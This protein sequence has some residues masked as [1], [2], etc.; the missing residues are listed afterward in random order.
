AA[1]AVR[2]IEDLLGDL[3]YSHATLDRLGLQRRI[4]EHLDDIVDA[5]TDLIRGLAGGDRRRDGDD[6]SGQGSDRGR[7]DKDARGGWNRSA[8][9]ETR[10]S[11]IK[12][13]SGVC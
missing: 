11:P 8:I 1:R 9:D 5:L 12:M 4:V 13:S 3:P 7:V 6:Q 10:E 2:I